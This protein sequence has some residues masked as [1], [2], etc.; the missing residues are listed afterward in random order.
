MT[1]SQR[2]FLY[3]VENKLHIIRL[4]RGVVLCSY[5]DYFHV[6]EISRWGKLIRTSLENDEI[7]N[8]YLKL[9]LNHILRHKQIWLHIEDPFGRPHPFPHNFTPK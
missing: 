6:M 9:F 2:R 3:H 4:K 8:P 7:D 1:E 5:G